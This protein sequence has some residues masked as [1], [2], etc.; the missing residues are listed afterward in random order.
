MS[1]QVFFSLNE[2]VVDVRRPVPSPP[3]IIIPAQA[4]PRTLEPWYSDF[5]RFLLASPPGCIPML[6]SITWRFPMTNNRVDLSHEMKADWSRSIDFIAQNV[7]PLSKLTIT[8]DMWCANTIEYGRRRGVA[9]DKV[10]KPLRKLK[11]LRDLIVQICEC[12]G[13]KD[14]AEE[15]RLEGLVTIE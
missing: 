6:R 15:L 3:L 10:V 9:R 4:S 5:S 13:P 7:D 11:G 8:L 1:A 14:A 12:P 2:F